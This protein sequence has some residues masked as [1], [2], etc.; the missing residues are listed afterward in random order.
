MQSTITSTTSLTPQQILNQI[1]KPEYIKYYSDWIHTAN[2]K[3]ARGLQLLG[4]IYKHKGSKKFRAKPPSVQLQQ[5]HAQQEFDFQKAEEMYRKS[6][7]TS[8]YG[9]EFGYLQKDLKP[10]QN[11]FKYKK[12]SDLPFAKPLSDLA[13]LFIDNWIELNDELEF[14]EL[15]LACLRSLHSRCIAQEVPKTEM[16]TKYEWK[17]DW[18]LSKPIRIDKAGSDL[19]AYKTNYNAIFKQRLKQEHINEQLKQLDNSDFAKQL[20]IFKPFKI[21]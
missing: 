6:Q 21:N 18:N 8:S 16:K 10:T 20:K 11:V 7:I 5:L 17:E 9:Q 13:K 15:V 19:K 4:A 12:C 1:I 14:Q 3:E 2:E